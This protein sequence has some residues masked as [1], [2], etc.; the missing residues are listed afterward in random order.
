M[1]GLIVFGLLGIYLLLLVWATRRGWRW[2]VEKKGWTGRKRWLGAAIGF[3]IVY[4]PVFWDWIPTFVMHQYYCATEAGFWVYK[5]LDQWKAE[6]PGVMETL[7]TQQVPPHKFEGDE[8]NL[9]STTLWNSRIKSTLKRQGPIF[10]HRSRQ[11]NELIDIK[12]NEILARYVDFSTSHELRQA[13][14][15]GWKFWLAIDHCPNYRDKGIQFGK[16]LEQLKGAE[17][18]NRVSVD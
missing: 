10:L 14:W 4:L 13:G 11:E 15:Y 1:F 6:N 17:T 5:T 7:T 3:L 8:N 18:I 2:G 9:T 12:S 16:F